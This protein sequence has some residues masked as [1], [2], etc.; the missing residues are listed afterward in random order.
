ME[1]I[2][3]AMRG[4]AERVQ[5]TYAR[6]TM[7]LVDGVDPARHAVR[8]RLQPQDVLTGWLP[9][10]SVGVGAGWQVHWLPAIGTQVKV[11]FQEGGQG[12]GSLPA[13]ST[14]ISTRPRPRLLAR[15]G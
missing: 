1:G 13:A 2:R 6:L 3:N 12:A 8:V 5:A 9:V 11:E 10:A 15:P 14:T 7:G 4:E